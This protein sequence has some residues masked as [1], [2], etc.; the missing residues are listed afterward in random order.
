M[1]RYI[2]TDQE[3]EN[4]IQAA[5]DLVRGAFGHGDMEK[6]QDELDRLERRVEAREVPEWATHFA[7]RRDYEVTYSDE[8]IPK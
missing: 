5:G 8:E 2:I 3:L 6:S 1:T 7:E 4:I